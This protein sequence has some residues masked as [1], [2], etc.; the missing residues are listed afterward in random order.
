MQQ[1]SVIAMKLM[2]DQLEM[3]MAQDDLVSEGKISQ[4]ESDEECD[5]WSKVC[6][7]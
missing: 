1:T 3:Q 6:E 2:T 5:E 7:K 4:E